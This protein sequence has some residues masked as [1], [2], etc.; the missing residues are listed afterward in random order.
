[1]SNAHAVATVTAALQHLLTAG[2]RHFAIT[3]EVTARPPDKA[4]RFDNNQL[5]VFLYHVSVD[6]ALR[7]MNPSGLLPGES[8]LPSLPLALHYVISAYGENNDDIEAHRLLG[9]AMSVLHD[10]P[11]LGPVEFTALVGETDL[12]LQVE[13]VRVTPQPLGVEEMYRLWMAFQTQYR[14]SAA[15]EVSVILIDSTRPHRTPLPVLARGE[16]DGGVTAQTGV[17]AP[18]PA[19]DSYRTPS[20]RPAVLTG[21]QVTLAGH[22]LA[23]ARTVRFRHRLAA[24]ETVVPTTVSADSVRVTVPQTLPAGLC[25]AEV[26]FDGDRASNELP[27]P[28]A[29]RVVNGLPAQVIR[30][31]TGSVRVELTCL[32][33]PVTGQQVSLL[34]GERQIAAEPQGAG[35]GAPGPGTAFT[36]ERAEPG[37]YLVRVRIDG[38]DSPLIDH[39][40]SPPAF[41][42][43]QK[44]TIA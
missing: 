18:F 21:D 23:D 4:R 32:P 30:T 41:D 39:S 15:Y 38:V 17:V 31:A 7:T 8:G 3:G 10:H 25:T 29:P 20:G 35:P 16:N 40:V 26:L 6:P 43:T 22:H 34:L 36:V 42:G 44:V 13:R 19:V 1:M 33:A 12:D 11:I 14:I 37:E 27:V 5:N 24:P 28:L 2:L 9:R